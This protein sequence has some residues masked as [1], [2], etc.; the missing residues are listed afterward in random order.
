[1]HRFVTIFWEHGAN[2]LRWSFVIVLDDLNEP[3]TQYLRYAQ[4]QLYVSL[5]LIRCWKMSTK[6]FLYSIWNSIFREIK[7]NDLQIILPC[8]MFTYQSYTFVYKENY[9][10][11]C[12]NSL[13][14]F[15]MLFQNSRATKNIA[16]LIEKKS[17]IQQKDTYVKFGFRVTGTF[18]GPDIAYSSCH[19]TDYVFLDDSSRNSAMFV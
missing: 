15:K 8:E 4:N 13:W 17:F 2:P 9:Y 14:K 11:T 7:S 5:Y 10:K 19:N 16:A 18:S 6:W 12:S 1:M 3:W